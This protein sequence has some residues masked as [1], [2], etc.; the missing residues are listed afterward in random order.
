MERLV[1][2]ENNI[3]LTE[4]NINKIVLT[5][6]NVNSRIL[7][8]YIIQDRRFILQACIR[9]CSLGG[10][11]AHLGRN[12]LRVRVLAVSNTYLMFLEPTVIPVLSGSLGTYGLI[13]KLCLKE[14]MQLCIILYLNE[15]L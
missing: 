4:N 13:Q 12:R 10:I 3:V 15:I 1:L 5:S 9:H 7:V 11:G 2:T 14:S 6:N 8:Y